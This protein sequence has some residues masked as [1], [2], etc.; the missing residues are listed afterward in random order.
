MNATREYCRTLHSN[1]FDKMADPEE[2]RALV[3]GASQDEE[4]N[5]FAPPCT[6]NVDNIISKLLENKSNPNKQV[7]QLYA[8]FIT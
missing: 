2:K 8:Y 4:R 6:L 1:V 7:R 3:Q 5:T